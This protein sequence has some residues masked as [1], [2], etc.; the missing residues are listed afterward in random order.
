MEGYFGNE[1]VVTALKSALLNRTRRRRDPETFAESSSSL[2]PVFILYGVPGT[3]KTHLVRELCGHLGLHLY[4]INADSAHQKYV[5]EGEEKIR[6][7]FEEARELAEQNKEKDIILFIDE[8]DSLFPRSNSDIYNL[9]VNVLKMELTDKKNGQLILIGC[10]NNPGCWPPA[11]KSR[12]T[13]EFL[14]APPSA[15]TRKQFFLHVMNREDKKAKMSVHLRSAEIEK[16]VN[17]TENYSMRDLTE[18]WQGVCNAAL[19]LTYGATHFKQ[20]IDAEDDATFLPCLCNDE[21]CGGIKGKIEDFAMAAIKYVPITLEL[22]EKVFGRN[23]GKVD[24]MEVQKYEDYEKYGKFSM[25]IPEETK[26][27]SPKASG[28]VQGTGGNKN[29]SIVFGVSLLMIAGACA[30]LYKLIIAEY[31]ILLGIACFFIFSIILGLLKICFCG[32]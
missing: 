30:M 12:I 26:V 32:F 8:I 21:K 29:C 27:R 14:V 1:E 4:E 5:G 6:G 22:A 13:A 11:I 9:P 15:D 17:L 31:W 19:D 3:G 18:G 7:H 16:L 23:V 20:T 10:T 24:L 2:M 25:E 28:T